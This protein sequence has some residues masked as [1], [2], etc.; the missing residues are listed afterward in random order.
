MRV[1]TLLAVMAVSF[2][3]A[4]PAD[5]GEQKLRV[6]CFGAHPDDCELKAGGVAAR[7]AWINSE[8]AWANS[9]RASRSACRTSGE[10]F[11]CSSLSRNSLDA[12]EK[13]TP[14]PSI[15][16]VESLAFSSA[17]IFPTDFSSLAAFLI[18]AA[19]FLSCSPATF[20]ESSFVA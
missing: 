7:I 6:I 18:S 1:S 19:L 11:P 12:V 16:R 9:A 10:N 2:Y 8:D 3:G 15:P 17:L 13:R 20:A 14:V 4:A 5:A